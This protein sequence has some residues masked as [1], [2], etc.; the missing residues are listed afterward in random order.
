[1]SE[2]LKT[3]TSAVFGLPAML[4]SLDERFG[5]LE[6]GVGEFAEWFRV[7][8]DREERTA[9]EVV[10]LRVEMMERLDRQQNMLT[11][12]RDDIGVN[13]AAVGHVRDQ[14]KL[15]RNDYDAL[16]KQ[17]SVVH[18]RLMQLEQ[19]VENKEDGA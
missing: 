14:Y 16:A 19:K 11:H 18:R 17:L 3:L 8:Q 13:S 6:K 9:A 5:R 1:M 2:D 10:R 4:V 7:I 12:V 15:V